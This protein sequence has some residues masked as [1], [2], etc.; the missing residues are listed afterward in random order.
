MEIHLISIIIP[1]LNEADLIDDQIRLLRQVSTFIPIEII[2]VDGGSSDNT[3][4]VVAKTADHFISSP[5]KNRSAQM[6]IGAEVAKGE[7]FIFLHA[8]TRLPLDWQKVIKSCFESKDQKVSAGA[9]KLKFDSDRLI[10]KTIAFLANCRTKITGV[11]QGDQA[12]F[13]SSQI[14]KESGGFP[15]TQLMEEYLFIPKLR[16]LGSIKILNHAV[17]TSVRRHVKNGPIRNSLRNSFLI[18]L[19]YLGVSPK[20]L[21]TWYN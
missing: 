7:I 17:L 21:A 19:F 20:R 5:L 12:L 1:V 14:Y 3:V 16:K 10:Y 8:D 13:M 15:Q 6:H 11:P 4:E 9:F 18:S 2:I